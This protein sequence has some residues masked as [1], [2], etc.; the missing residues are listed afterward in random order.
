LAPRIAKFFLSIKLVKLVLPLFFS[1]PFSI[2]SYFPLNCLKNL[3]NK[4]KPV[5][6]SLSNNLFIYFHISQRQNCKASLKISPKRRLAWLPLRSSL[7]VSYIICIYVCMCVYVLLIE[8]VCYIKRESEWASAGG[9]HLP[10]FQCS[11]GFTWY[12][13]FPSFSFCCVPFFVHLC[14]TH[15]YRYTIFCI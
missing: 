4:I 10:L 2:S 12:A 8:C 11:K 9:R 1:F 6:L 14:Y 13:I 5:T 7:S 15:M 3:S